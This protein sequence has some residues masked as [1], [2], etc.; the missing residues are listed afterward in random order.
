MYAVL[1]ALPMLACDAPS[2]KYTQGCEY[3]LCEPPRSGVPWADPAKAHAVQRNW[4]KLEGTGG[5]VSLP[6]DVIEHGVEGI[7]RRSHCWI[8]AEQWSASNPLLNAALHEKEAMD[9][10]NQPDV[11]DI[12]PPRTHF[13]G[14]LPA[15][16][17]PGAMLRPNS[18]SSSPSR[19][20]KRLSSLNFG[21]EAL[22]LPAGVTPD[23]SA[24]VERPGSSH[25]VDSSK[26]FDAILADVNKGKGKK[27]R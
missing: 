24:P 15:P 4:Y 27:K 5:V 7:Y 8:M 17:S 16:P 1:Q 19:E 20:S 3:F 22:P 12:G 10:E 14:P 26:T 25:N 21:L 11:P 13:G 18:R 9:S 6:S 23:G 2:L